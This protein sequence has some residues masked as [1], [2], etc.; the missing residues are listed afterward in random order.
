VRGRLRLLAALTLLAGAGGACTSSATSYS[1]PAVSTASPSSTPVQDRSAAADG[2]ASAPQPASPGGAQPA[3]VPVDLALTGAL[4][5]HVASARTVA[6]CGVGQVGFAA[7][8]ELVVNGRPYLLGFQI[9]DFHGPGDYPVPP[10]RASLRPVSPGSGGGLL[11]AVAGHV[12]IAANQRSGRL[13]LTLGT[14]SDTRLQGTW[15][16]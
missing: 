11:P 13:Q 8:L 9:V 10:I 15:A 2:P 5:G 3:S 6:Q 4:S 12:S 16:C 7:Q 1:S 14:S